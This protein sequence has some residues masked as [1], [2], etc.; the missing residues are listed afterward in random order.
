MNDWLKG[1]K[2]RWLQTAAFIAV[3]V[4]AALVLRHPLV[5]WFSGKSMGSSGGMP[6]T[7]HAGPFTLKASLDPDPPSTE[8]NSLVLQVLDDTGKPV[9]DATVEVQYDMAAMGAMAEMK[10]NAKI[11]HE[12][13]GHYRAMFDLPMGGSFALKTSIRGVAGSAA[14]NFTLTVGNKGLTVLGGGMSADGAGPAGMNETTGLRP[15]EYPPIAL[16]ALRSA[17]DAAERTRAALARDDVA[18]IP[19][20]ATSIAQALKAAASAAPKDRSDLGEALSHA[21]SEAEHLARQ[22]SLD[23]TRKAFAGFN[24]DFLPLV[25]ADARLAS[26]LHVFECPMFD[27]ARWMQRAETAQNPYLG[28]KML[29][30]G[31]A[32]SWQA[33]P[34]AGTAMSG[35]LNAVD[36]YTCSMHPSVKQQT[37][38]KCPICGMDLVPVTKTQQEQGVVMIDEARRQLIGV[39]TGTVT[40][41]PMRRSFR[42]VGRVTYD[43]STFTD[44]NLKVRGW[45]TKLFVNETGQ[46]VTKGQPLFLLYSPEL[47]NAEQDFLLANQTRP[48]SANPIETDPSRVGLLARASRQRLHLLGLGDAQIDALTKSGT[49]SE[50]IAIPAPASGFVIE[51]D[52]V[53][54]SSVDA[55]MKLFRIAALNKVWVDAEVYEADLPQ[56]RVGQSAIVTL[57]YLP[58]RSYD[59]KVGYIY[60]SLDPMTRTGRVRVELAN[61]DLDLRPGMYASVE[62]VSDA[63]PWI[64]V[65]ASAVVYTGPRRLVFVDLG[66]GRF[67]PQEVHVGAESDGVYEVL[68]GLEPGDVVATSGIFLIAAE[69]RISTAAKYWDKS[70]GGPEPP[71]D[72]PDA[73][74]SMM[75]GAGS[76]STQVAP[77]AKP[78]PASM[79]VK[80]VKAMSPMSR[81]MGAPSSVP[82]T[83]VFS[84]PMHPEVR[85]RAPGKCPRCGMNL[86]PTPSGGAK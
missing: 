26:G 49:P 76:M 10:G 32:S 4:V 72:A 35:G 56:V 7:A 12:D 71:S 43:E 33:A 2:R 86:E 47:Y 59:A 60:P 74:K 21:A 54:G 18:G 62:L 42:A 37:S 53:E 27:H 6:V 81:S 15:I 16:D 30:C 44:V 52:V 23:D 3:L 41:G 70:P 36:H 68:S 50:N 25:G 67:R 61:K 48:A 77:S 19:E 38:G 22:K 1:N 45:I 8:G 9:E 85:S 51:K 13:G 63:R 69:A 14:Q 28:T 84:C 78:M 58:G 29:S 20:A 31:T 24:A 11:E 17:V 80:P 73:G 55:G 39:R 40:E 65:P 75:P 64:Q 34:A 57:D 46:R 79:T 66:E 82:P 5:A 83:T